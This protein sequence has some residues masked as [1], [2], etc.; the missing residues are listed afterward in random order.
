[1][2]AATTHTQSFLA[3][4]KEKYNNNSLESVNSSS[5]SNSDSEDEVGL[6]NNTNTIYNNNNTN[7]MYNN[8]AINNNNRKYVHRFHEVKNMSLGFSAGERDLWV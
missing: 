6:I 8:A 5:A 4:S 1:M 7:T 2:L 3:R